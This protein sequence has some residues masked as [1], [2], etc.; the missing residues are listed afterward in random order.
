LLVIIMAGYIFKTYDRIPAWK[1]SMSLNGQA[2]MVSDNSA[3]ANCFMATALYEQGRDAADAAVKKQLFDEAEYYAKRSLA[4]YPTYIA[5][6]QIYSGLVAERYLRDG[7]LDLLLD[8]FLKILDA[9]F[10]TEYVYQF[11]EYLNKRAPVD[12]MVDYY[13][14]AGY[15]MMARDKLEYAAGVK[16]LKLGESIAPNDARILYG[17]G[18]ALYEGGDQ[19]QGEEYLSRAYIINPALRNLN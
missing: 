5:A 12:K 11:V 13:Y 15:E 2:A 9:R 16:Y 19:V 1:D 18:K 7:N 3:R 10:E 6:N 8:E 17:I 4:I 14:K